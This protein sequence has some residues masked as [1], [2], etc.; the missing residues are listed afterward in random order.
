[1]QAYMCR[2]NMDESLTEEWE[3][4]QSQ[5]DELSQ[6]LKAKSDAVVDGHFEEA[7]LLRKREKEIKTML[8]RNTQDFMPLPEVTVADIEAVVSVWSGV[9]VERMQEGQMDRLTNLAAGLHSRVVGQE[10]AINA[11]ARA[12]RRLVA[13][14][15]C[16]C[17]GK[18][19][20]YRIASAGLILFAARE[21]VNSPESHPCDTVCSLVIMLAG[22]HSSMFF[23][24]GRKITLCF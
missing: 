21:D 14:A 1:M 13:D 7:E 5:A 3:V 16:P 10:N 22:F 9:P 4:M 2:K 17:S 8:Q 15:V 6:V 18:M 24:P 19:C 23:L 20:A 11:I 12:M